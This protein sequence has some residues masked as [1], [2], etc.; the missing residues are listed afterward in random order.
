[1]CPAIRRLEKIKPE[2]P[3]YAA[4]FM[5]LGEYVKHHVKD[6]ESEIFPKARRRKVNLKALGKKL[7]ARKIR[8]AA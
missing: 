2:D 3:K 4:T 7:M 8:L 6:E 5:V 1:M